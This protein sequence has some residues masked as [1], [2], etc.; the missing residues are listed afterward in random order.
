MNKAF[1][2]FGG[3][4]TTNLPDGMINPAGIAAFAGFAIILAVALLALKGYALWHA[5][6]KNDL[7]WFV[8]LL[9]LNTVGLLEIFYLYKNKLI[10]KKKS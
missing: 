1:H 8:A 5:A 3:T 4:F 2:M 9:L 6:R 10:L 7:S